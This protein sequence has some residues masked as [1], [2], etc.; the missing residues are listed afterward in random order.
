MWK[1]NNLGKETLSQ[2]IFLKSVGR[3]VFWK[4]K[5][6]SEEKC[7][8]ICF[9]KLWG[10]MLSQNVQKTFPGRNL[11]SKYEYTLVGWNVVSKYIKKVLWEEKLSQPIE[12][13]T[14]ESKFFLLFEYLSY[15]KS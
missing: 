9:F 12:N 3:N 6:N 10:E 7:H 5:K 11:F 15:K 2:N 8:K 14:D 1:K 4:Y 13:K